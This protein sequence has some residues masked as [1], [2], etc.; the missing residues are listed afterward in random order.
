[1]D[2]SIPTP[3]HG[4]RSPWRPLVWR[5]LAFAMVYLTALVG[6][7]MGVGVSERDLAGAGLAEKAYYALGLFVLGGLDIGT[8]EGGPLL[9][10]VL[11]WTGYFLA[12][13]ITASALVEAVLRLIGPLTLRFRPLAGHVVLA[14]AGRLTLLYVR[15]LRE[16]DRRRTI[17]VV[18]RNPSHPL[19]SE[20]R[21]VHRAVVVNGDVTRDEVLRGLRLARAR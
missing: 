16:G 7:A 4:M 1:M 19:A 17:V 10:R 5:G 14:G 12:P 2:G 15:R 13:I 11:L 8:P 3:A 21:D 18:E 6:L 20:L 9:G